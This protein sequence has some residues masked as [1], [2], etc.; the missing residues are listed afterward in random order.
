MYNFISFWT[1]CFIDFFYCQ[2]PNRSRGSPCFLWIDMRRSMNDSIKTRRDKS[3]MRKRVGTLKLRRESITFQLSKGLFD[4]TVIRL[5]PG[6]KKFSQVPS[7]TAVKETYNVPWTTSIPH[8][9]SHWIFQRRLIYPIARR[10]ACVGEG[11]W[12]RQVPHKFSLFSQK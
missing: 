7:F 4:R 9:T 5:F 10:S 6:L 1:I 11:T 2:S 8:V 3:W 12:S